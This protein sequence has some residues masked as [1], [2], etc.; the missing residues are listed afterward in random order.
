MEE[1]AY[2]S[3]LSLGNPP[4]GTIDDD[5]KLLSSCNEF[6]G[7]TMAIDDVLFAPEAQAPCT[8][9]STTSTPPEKTPTLRN[10]SREIS[11]GE[12]GGSSCTLL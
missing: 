3:S 9:A 1:G 6:S 10:T 12:S 7:D 8:Q 2:W 5:V 4:S 11:D